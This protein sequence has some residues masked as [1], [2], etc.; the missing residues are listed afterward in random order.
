M[1]NKSRQ[2]INSPLFKKIF[3]R[4][5]IV[6]LVSLMIGYIITFGIFTILRH[7]AFAS[8]YDLANM[9]GA[10]WSTLHGKFFMLR[11][12]ENLVSRLSVHADFILILL[13]PLY[14]IW[15]NV[16]M[17]LIAQTVILALGAIP[18]Y[19]LARAI[20]KNKIASLTIA[21][22]YLL[23]PAMQ[24][25]NMDDFHGVTLAIPFLLAGFYFAYVKKW[26]W[27][28]VFIFLALL[29]KEE[30]SLYI[31]MLGLAIIFVFKQRKVGIITSAVGLVWFFVMVY[32]LI[33]HLGQ[34]TAAW[35][36]GR[37]GALSSVGGVVFP[38]LDMQ[39]M[40][41]FFSS[42]AVT[43]Y[44]EL[45]K[46]FGYAPLLGFPWLL[47]SLPEIAINVLSNNKAQ[48]TIYYHYVSGVIPSLVIAAIFGLSYLFSFLNHFAFLR[49]YRKY[50]TYGICLV[51]L[52]VALRVN[53]HYSPL[54]TTPSSWRQIYNVTS[55]DKAFE[56][57]LQCIPKD[58]SISASIEIRPHVNHKENVWFVPYAT[59]S[60]QFIALITQNRLVGN[61]EPKVYENQL[62]PILLLDKNYEL[63]FRSEHFYLFE[64]KM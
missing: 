9:D 62:I 21:A 60:A 32:W 52:F 38:K 15:D 13:S 59:S 25:A 17:L 41:A 3:Q 20:L 48:E 19:L 42:N 36:W 46:P 43:Y 27:Y 18:T 1:S 56:K 11:F 10:L 47:L 26:V 50:I 58:A 29:T 57:V 23:N 39:T 2:I 44:N 55:E 22:L 24:W 54:P 51:L 31:V 53:Y 12:A 4:W 45:I 33:P 37:Y 64:R 7:N 63:L 5:D 49:E 6:V 34:T 14:Y 28:T 61:Y 16:R 35:V 40:Q 8:Y 30:I